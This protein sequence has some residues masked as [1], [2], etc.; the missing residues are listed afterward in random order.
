MPQGGCRQSRADTAI[1]ACPEREEGNSD[2]AQSFLPCTFL[3][4]PACGGDGPERKAE[5]AGDESLKR[6]TR[7]SLDGQRHL[8]PV[9]GDHEGW[10]DVTGVRRPGTAG[11]SATTWLRSARRGAGARL[12]AGDERHEGF[13]RSGLAEEEVLFGIDDQAARGFVVVPGDE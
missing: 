9:L 4:L 10:K 2:I 3:H 5:E 8:S 13:N 11:R 7:T 12:D 1:P 6:Q